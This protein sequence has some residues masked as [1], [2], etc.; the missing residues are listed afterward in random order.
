MKVVIIEDQAEIVEAVSMCFELR[1]PDATILSTGEG[2]KGLELIEAE[3][4][5]VVVLDLGLPDIEGFEVLR[6]IHFFSDVPIVV[7]TVRNQK[8]DIVKGL[9]LGA[10]DYITKPFDHIEFL[11]RVKAVL[12]RTSMPQ[13]KGNAK[14]FQSGKLRIDFDT[15]EVSLSGERVKLT[16]IEYNLLQHLA[17]NAGHVVSHQTLLEKVWGA[18]Y[19]NATNYLKVYIQ[20][21]R[22]KLF[23]NL[24]APELILTERR[25]GYK[26]VKSS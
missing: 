21:L 14:P 11:A 6:Q 25:V 19:T 23:D 12:R 22:A 18:E 8:M 9:E 16:P 5:D 15:R 26:L 13:L 10:D 7:L 17:K 2:I 3:L 20:R 4:P 1:W 24:S